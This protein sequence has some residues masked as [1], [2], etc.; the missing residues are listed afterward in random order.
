M[1]GGV[2]GQLFFI[3]V[4]SILLMKQPVSHS[5]L[6]ETHCW[7]GDSEGLHSCWASLEK[8]PL[9]ASHNHISL[10]NPSTHLSPIRS[11]N[12]QGAINIHWLLFSICMVSSNR[13]QLAAG[14][15]M[16]ILIFFID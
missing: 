7:E 14:F 5:Q 15:D 13:Q 11:V 2:H 10:G 16:L 4:E 1:Q 6:S 9:P 3:Q 12:I 8:Q